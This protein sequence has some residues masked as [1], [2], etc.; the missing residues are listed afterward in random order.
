MLSPD[1]SVKKAGK[2]LL[3]ISK[4]QNQTIWG[5][6]TEKKEKCKGKK[7]INR[8]CAL[9]RQSKKNKRMMRSIV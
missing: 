6:E 1:G 9:M 3:S 7:A 4:S 5:K 2:S 8:K